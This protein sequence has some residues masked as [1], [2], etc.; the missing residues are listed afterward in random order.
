MMI[1]IN[2]PR[3]RHCVYEPTFRCRESFVDFVYRDPR[4]LFF[5]TVITIVIFGKSSTFSDCSEI[6]KT[7]PTSNNKVDDIIN[8]IIC[9]VIILALYKLFNGDI[10]VILT[11]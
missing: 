3:C 1:M 8:E 6:S 9:I 4:N 7:A 10:S 5:H 11:M 2:G